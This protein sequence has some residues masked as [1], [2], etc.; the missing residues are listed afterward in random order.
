MKTSSSVA[1]WVL[2]IVSFAPERLAEVS[3]ACAK[4][5][6]PFEPAMTFAHRYVERL[7]WKR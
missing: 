7:E 3:A 2:S 6:V 5:G 1:L 4:H